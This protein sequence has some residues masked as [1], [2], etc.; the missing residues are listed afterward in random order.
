MPLPIRIAG[1]LVALLA[2]LP[3]GEA[4]AQF[5]DVTGV[6]TGFPIVGITYGL[7]WADFDGNSH[8]DCFICRHYFK[9]IIY[10]N[11]GT[12][13]DYRIFQGPFDPPDDHHGA[14]IADFDNDG[15]ADVYLTGGADA[16]ASEVPKKMYRNDGGYNFTNVAAAWGLEDQEARGRSPSGID[17]Q[18]DGDL[19]VFVAK[20][21]RVASPNSLFLND[22]T[23][24]FTDIA[25]AAGLDDAFGSVGGLWG[26]YDND[27]DPDLFISGEEEVTF[28][29]RLYRNEG[30]LTFV[31]V[32]ATALPGVGQA[33]AAAWGDYDNDGDLDLALGQGDRGLF[34][35]VA[36]SPDSIY[37]FF[38]TRFGDDGLDGFGYVTTGD[39]STFDV[40]IDGFYRPDDIYLGELEQNPV[41]TP[42]STSFEDIVGSPSFLPGES[43]AMYIWTVDL[44]GIWQL[45]G[46]APPA[47][48][49]S[50]AGIVKTNG[51]I[52]DV[53]TVSLE[54]VVPGPRGTRLWRNDGGTFTDV[55]ASVG[56][57]DT[58]NAHFLDFVDVDQ[59]GWLDLYV[60]NKGDTAAQNQPN[61]F[62]RNQGNGTFLDETAAWGL[63]GPDF[64]LGDA[65]A[66]EDY[67]SDGDLDVMMTAGTGPK[68]IAELERARLYRN[69]GPTGNRLR[70]K[71]LGTLSTRDGYGAWVTCVTPDGPQH[72]YVTGNT[73]RGG[74]TLLNPYFGLG[75]HSSADMVIVQWPS[76]IV[77]LYEDV[78]AGVVTLQEGD[79]VVAG[80]EPVATTVRFAARPFPQ[81]SAGSVTLALSGRRD[82]PAMI[83]IYDAAGRR[84]LEQELAPGTD[85]FEWDGRAGDG[86]RVSAGLY[87]ARASEGDRRA[88]TKIVRVGP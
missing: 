35:A 86:R 57:A 37:F 38:N 87:F 27:G 55:T 83:R 45:R 4:R 44:A 36:W 24:F 70:L 47:A 19:D 39:S 30:D 71:L 16:G 50:F 34:D 60:L 61:V 62:H 88:V 11:D 85:R 54:S 53:S 42:F 23:P 22:G 80:P 69:D 78:P 2:G 48:G 41:F 31:D 18:G 67:D 3:A 21:A 8:P 56:I 58:V 64:G 52:T 15:D 43:L 26:D 75:T 10:E 46:N 79:T 77:D 66:F 17:L 7:G 20:S 63:A 33:A 13:M 9:P 51:Q 81:P 65:F 1:L 68:F 40:A 12:E 84:V 59:D 29:S 74:P 49:H 6:D 28:E 32:T 82:R 76:G 5:T 25:A 73:W 72:R 14:L